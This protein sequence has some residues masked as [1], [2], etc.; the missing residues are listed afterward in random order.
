M[1]L[2]ESKKWFDELK[3]S[4]DQLRLAV[5]SAGAAGDPVNIPWLIEMMKVDELA[6]VSGEA[7]T[8]LTGIYLAYDDL[9][10]D[11]P[12]GF[13]AGPTENPEDEN[14]EMDM[15]EDL[16]GPNPELISKRWDSIKSQ[17]KNGTRYLLGKPIT[18]EWMQQVLR[19]GRQRQRA[20]A[21]LELTTFTPG[22]PLFEVRAPGFVQRKIL[23]V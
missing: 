7:F 3:I 10:K 15:D 17:Y 11:K 14:V 4:K 19:T 8:M 20:A 12:E 1:S 6:R 22:Q 21:A 23:N 2:Y 18:K 5:I 9:E 13:E 16:P